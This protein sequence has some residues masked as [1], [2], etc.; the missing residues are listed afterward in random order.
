MLKPHHKR[1][2]YFEL[3]NEIGE[4][5][6][7]SRVYTAYDPQ[8]DDTIVIKEIDKNRFNNVDEYF[9]EASIL[10]SGRHSN[11]V[12][13]KY[14][15]QNDDNIYLAMPYFQNG[16]IKSL[17]NQ[18]Y[19]TI[20]EIIVFA[21]QFLSALHHIHTKKLIHFDLKPDNILISDRGEALVSDFGLA[22]QLKLNGFAEQ[23]RTYSKMTPP[24]AFHD[25]EFTSKFDI[26][27]AGLT[28]YRLCNGDNKFYS[29]FDQFINNGNLDRHSFRHAVINGQF[30]DRDSFLEHIPQRMINAIRNTLATDPNDRTSSAIE[31]LNEISGVDGELLDWKYSEENGIKKWIK[32][33]EDRVIKLEIDNE[34][35]S[36]A[37]QKIGDGNERRIIDYCLEDI[38]RRDI[39]KF[40]SSH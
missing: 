19:L 11:V 26:Y 20:R 16:S 18:R 17:L 5:G 25:Y 14:A 1:D 35:N 10:H 15:C 21:T 23:D 38:G 33:T 40:L 28:L 29:H 13:I 4:E 22:K 2:I 12:P 36:T 31:V 8:L 3:R 32:S 39:K 37:T 6:K 7:N 30:P 27:Q 34:N 24:E 9:L